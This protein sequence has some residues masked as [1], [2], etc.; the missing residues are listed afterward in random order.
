MS[1]DDSKR[2]IALKFINKI[3]T[4]IG[5]DQ[6]DDLTDFIDIDRDLI[7][8][9]KNKAIVDEMESEITKHFDKKKIGYYNRTKVKTIIIT[10]LKG[11]IDHLNLIM[12]SREVENYVQVDGLK[13]RKTKI[14]FTIKEKK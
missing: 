3:L 1:I 13:Y 4:N 9:D 7:I 12:E 10:Y 2:V 11:M 5:K 6:I 8:K 14:L